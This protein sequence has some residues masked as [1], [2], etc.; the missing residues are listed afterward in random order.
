MEAEGR[1]RDDEG[2]R[3][4]ALFRYTVIATLV[5]HELEAE[6]VDA[7]VARIA[8]E[9]HYLP[10]KGRI[11]VGKSSVYRWLRQY[12]QGGIEA[13]RPKV[14]KDKGRRRKL[15]DEVLERAV[16]LRKEGSKRSTATV[17]DILVREGTL[18]GVVPHRSTFDRHLDQR[19]ASR[20][21]LKVLGSRPTKRMEFS[22]FGDLWVGD[23][24]HGPLI[25]APDGRP[26]TAKLGAFIDHCTRYPVADR[27]YL[28]E[29]TPTLRDTLQR[30]FLTWG[31]PDKAYADR[32]AV[33]RSRALKYSLLRIGVK[34]VH[35]KAYYS[36]GRGVIERWWQVVQAF[37][38]EVSLREEL[39]TLH[40]LNLLWEAYRQLRYV[41]AVHSSLGIS[42][43]EAVANVKPRPIAPE[44]VREL[45]LIPD[46]RKV[47]KKNAC[48]S[49]ESCSFQCEAWL[50]DRW[51]QVRFD[52]C[53]LSSVLIYL[54]GEKVQKAFPQVPNTT[55]EPAPE[56]VASV[57][58]T[59]LRS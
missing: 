13:L 34:L 57:P 8:G 49:V 30:A 9:R 46:K 36:Q 56:P 55:P 32:G 37:E 6:G 28:A 47:N 41:E 29:D 58:G 48:V 43:A 12:R 35:S 33:Y 22:S 10:G 53:D 23:Y 25:L 42:P 4:V 17:V 51:V 31:P 18:K 3:M 11:R 59:E 26:V 5:E 54:D 40:E 39:L 24:H 27:Y 50:R 2:A 44:V 19:G 38:Y 15:S 20:R 45:F 21:R 16:E 14:R 7:E 1:Y 52:P